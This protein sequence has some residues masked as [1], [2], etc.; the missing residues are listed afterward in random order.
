VRLP[1]IIKRHAPNVGRIIPTLANPTL[2]SFGRSS[3][4]FCSGRGVWRCRAW[5]ST[6]SVVHITSV[7]CIRRHLCY[8][9]GLCVCVCVCV[10]VWVCARVRACVCVCARARVR[11]S[12]SLSLSVCVCVCVRAECAQGRMYT[13][14]EL[15]A[16][17]LL[18]IH[19]H[20]HARAQGFH[21]QGFPVLY[22]GCVPEYAFAIQTQRQTHCHPATEHTHK[23]CSQQ[24]NRQGHTH[25]ISNKI[26]YY[27]IHKLTGMHT[28]SHY[29]HTVSPTRRRTPPTLAPCT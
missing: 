4:R 12:L 24:K 16:L 17:Q 25:V 28:V 3:R 6:A 14:L 8:T 15:A 26:I 23:T 21:A 27:H 5:S 13:Y 1:N 22:A 20:M 2:P 7:Q 10:S 29:I 11:L 9:S 18:Q 19:T